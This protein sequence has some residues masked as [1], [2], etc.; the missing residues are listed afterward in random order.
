MTTEPNLTELCGGEGERLD[1][2]TD[3]ATFF[4]APV[5]GL[6][7]MEIDAKLVAVSQAARLA[8]FVGRATGDHSFWIDAIRSVHLCLTSLM[9]EALE[10]SA[11]IG[12]MPEKLAGKHLQWLA[13]DRAS[14]ADQPEE[15]TISFP[16]LVDAI[17]L[18][19]RLEYGGAVRMS[20]EQQSALKWL[21]WVRGLIDHPKHTDWSIPVLDVADQFRTLTSLIPPIVDAAGH[22]FN[23][24]RRK[25]IDTAL[26][27]I[28]NELA[29]HPGS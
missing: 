23:G 4:D 6:L 5:D 3:W 11:G 22:R 27:S 29:A 18:Q 20:A 15:R 10:G 8:E 12:A 21:N 28:I 24:A 17:Q 25:E 14:R 16:E 26:Q 9:F 13:A 7:Y 2:A 19:D 1:G